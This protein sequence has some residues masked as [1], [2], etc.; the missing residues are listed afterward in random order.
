MVIKMVDSVNKEIL[1]KRQLEILNYI[2]KYISENG[3]SPS[4]RDICKGCNLSS[5]STAHSH[6]QTLINKG[7]IKKGDNKFRTLE[8]LDDEKLYSLPLILDINLLKDN[9]T[10]Q[11]IK[12]SNKLFDIDNNSYIL[13]ITDPLNN[14]YNNYLII[15][16]LDSYNKGDLIVLEN[17][18]KIVIKAYDNDFATIYGKVSTIINNIK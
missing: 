9:Y 14:Y 7:Y 13:K 6:I 2:K 8:I 12:M 10:T 17:D 15:N 5:S 11:Y 18:N 1:T 3:Y 16:K 4:V